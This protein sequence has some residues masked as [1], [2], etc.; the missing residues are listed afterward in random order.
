[1]QDTREQL[2]SARPARGVMNAAAC[3]R[4][5][6]QTHG[7]WGRASAGLTAA[8][9]LLAIAAAASPAHAT[10]VQP[11]WNQGTGF[12]NGAVWGQ[13]FT[14]TSSEGLVDTVS[15]L[16]AAFSTTGPDVTVSAKLY[17]GDGFGGTLLGTSSAVLIPV[18][19]PDQAWIDFTLPATLLTPGSVYSMQFTASVSGTSGNAW[20]RYGLNSSTDVYTAG[21]QLL[22]SGAHDAGGNVKRDMAFRVVSATAPTPGTA[23]ALAVGG[24]AVG[25]RRRR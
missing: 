3:G 19:T 7:C 10:I 16:Y 24:L 17:S 21:W 13:S 6:M 22:P 15:L 18:S 25:R 5:P 2:D 4:T 11:T 8:A 9:G 20:Y 23:V 12:S 14:A 1:M